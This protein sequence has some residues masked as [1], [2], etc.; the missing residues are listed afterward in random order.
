MTSNRMRCTLF[1]GVVVALAAAAPAAV[2]AAQTNDAHADAAPL[3]VAQAPA[4]LSAAPS[5]QTA[6]F[7]AVPSHL[8]GVRRAAAEGPDAL[9]R[10]IW[11]TRMIYDFYYYDF[12]PKE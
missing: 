4:A 1:G 9:R 5:R 2:L 12:V 3:V 8:R 11:R 10:Y 6:A 7:D